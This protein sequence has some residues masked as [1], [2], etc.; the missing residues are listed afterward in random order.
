MRNHKLLYTS[1]YD[2]GLEHLLL[3][4]PKILKKYPD[5]TLDCAYGWV[6][7]DALCANNPERMEWKQKMVE[8]L[9][10]KGITE[11]GR[12]GKKELTELQEKCGILA[13]PSHFYEIFCIS[14]VEAQLHG[15]V[16]VTTDIGALAETVQCGVT[17]GGDINDKT[18][19]EE[20]LTA[21]LDLMGNQEKWQKLSDEGRIWAKQYD[22]KE[23]AQKWSDIFEQSDKSVKLT[24][25]TPTI[26]RG[27]WNIMADNLSKQTYRNFE[28]II[29]DDYPKDRSDTA[30]EYA[31]KYKLDIKY[32]RG[33]KRKVQRTY[34]LCNANNTVLEHATGEVLV[35]LQDFILIPLDGLEQIA[36]LYRKNPDCLQALPD[37]YFSPS[38]TPDKEKED[39]FNGK[40]EVIGDF[41]R[42]NIRIQNLGLRYTENPLDFEQN[43]GAVP[44]KIAKELGGW[45]EATDEGLGYDN[46]EFAYRGLKMG[47]KILIDENNVAVCLDLWPTLKDSTENGG[48]ERARRLNDPR[49]LF[50]MAMI[51]AKKLPLKITQEINDKIELLYD[52]PKEVTDDK[53]VEWI[54]TNQEKIVLGWLK[55]YENGK[56]FM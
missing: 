51:E 14:V 13:Y 18:V 11:H 6:T 34:G 15:C 25:Y 44:I 49:Y 43:W 52:I 47:Y 3:M 12:I 36:T 20:Y 48:K 40:T 16:P 23:I 5:A 31:E 38:I 22:W 41:I 37:M 9:K 28:W 35:F 33:K 10:Q 32:V 24:V 21:L 29:V 50:Y 42:Q 55:K 8:L 26:R 39:W 7:F 4:W 19:Q 17:V 56:S 46:T 2:R 1:S 27:F 53:V 45:I 54:K 30:R